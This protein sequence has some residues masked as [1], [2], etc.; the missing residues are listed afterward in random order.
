MAMGHPS[1]APLAHTLSILLLLPPSLVSLSLL[2]QSLAVPLS[3]SLSLRLIL[4][5]D[6]MLVTCRLFAGSLVADLEWIACV[7]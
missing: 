6:L 1:E 4:V 2:D 3:N 7:W 5:L